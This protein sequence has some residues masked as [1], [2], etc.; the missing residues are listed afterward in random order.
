MLETDSDVY[1]R[2]TIVQVDETSTKDHSVEVLPGDHT[3][4]VTWVKRRDSNKGGTVVIPMRAEA[5]RKYTFYLSSGLLFWK[6]RKIKI[7]SAPARP[8]PT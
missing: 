5:G 2:V 4:T 8:P 3:V 1:E 7:R 6:L